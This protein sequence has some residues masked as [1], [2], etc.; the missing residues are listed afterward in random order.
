MAQLTLEQV[1]LAKRQSVQDF[2]STREGQTLLLQV[3]IAAD[4]APP[5]WSPRRDK[6]LREF[7]PQES[8]L[9]GSVYALA[10]RNAGFRW[11]LVGE[12]GLIPRSRQLLETAEFGRGWQKL[13]M[14]LSTDMLTQDNGGFVEIIRPARARVG[15]KWYPAISGRNGS[16]DKAW[17][18]VLNKQ[19]D[20]QSV[21]PLDVTDSE[22]DLPV[23]LAHLDAARCRR[24][25][26]PVYPVVYTDRVGREHKL[27]YYQVI[28]M[29][30]MPSPDEKRHGVGYSFVSRVLRLAQTIRDTQ[31]YEQEKISGRFARAVHLTNIDPDVIMDAIKDQEA[32]NDARGLLRYSQ[33]IIAPTLDPNAR[34][35][36]VTIPLAE[37]PEGYSRDDAYRWYIAAVALAAGE[38]YSFL[39]PM[40]GRRLGSASEVEVQQKEARGKS[41][42]YFMDTLQ[43]QLNYSGI[44]PPG[45]EFRF[46][47]KDYEEQREKDDA[48]FR[49]AR[50][51]EIRIKSGEI[52]PAIARQLAADAGDLDRRYLEL[53]GERDLTPELAQIPGPKDQPPMNIPLPA[54]RPEH[55]GPAGEQKPQPPQEQGQKDG[56][57]KQ[58][59][60]SIPQ[61]LLQYMNYRPNGD[62]EMSVYLPTAK[63]EPDG[64]PLPEFFGETEEISE[65][66]VNRA[67]ERWR[68]NMPPEFIDLLDADVEVA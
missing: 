41:S 11:E 52:T 10:A 46:K 13:I 4:E 19:G 2:P 34:P 55:Q 6:Y 36:N 22:Y 30:D 12:Q 50:D 43:A 57:Q 17:Y 62:M 63:L 3:A 23:G 61:G 64:A 60:M 67:I 59:G 48:A 40:P 1:R 38:H 58:A 68:E 7:W 47:E 8:F 65:E 26:D 44:F 56:G 35:Y 66:D 53:M 42:R 20:T 14:K 25:G 21:D 31:V 5:W 51:R 15:G 32:A 45:L 49:R 54:P 24:T 28:I 33:P 37:L 39:A 29:A 16:G 18:A 27:A 9:A